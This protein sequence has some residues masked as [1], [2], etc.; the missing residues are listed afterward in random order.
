MKT[1][2]TGAKG[3]LGQ[4]I[5]QQMLLQNIEYIGIDAADV[6]ITHAQATRDLLLAARP[7]VVIHCA[8]YTAVDRAEDE[9]ALCARVNADATS[10]IAKACREMDA[11][12]IYIS[13]D[14]VFSGEK[15][16]LYETDDA[17]GP[18][19]VYGRTKLAGEEAVR[20]SQA[21][22]AIVRVSWTYGSGGNNFVKTMLRLG[23]ERDRVSV[24]SDQVGSPT[25]T[26]D[27]APLLCAM[28]QRQTEGIFHATNEG[29]CSW[30]DFARAI[31][32]GVGLSCRVEDI[33]S[34]QYPAR[35]C[36][37]QN[38]RLS[39]RSLDEAGFDRLSNWQEALVRFLQTESVRGDAIRAEK[40]LHFE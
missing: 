2:I 13:T 20:T 38:S 12:M 28:A 7:D 25:Y 10:T 4:D 37:P 32:A 11:H 5:C 31:F 35:A 34:A 18:K 23:R 3:Q 33:P 40:E 16:G 9:V 27:L 19:S 21:R 22:H 36:R 14:Y 24:V 8:A 39:K 30:A 15:N 1:L 17:V 26:A 29:F 6:N